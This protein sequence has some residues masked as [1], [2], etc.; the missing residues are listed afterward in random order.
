MPHLLLDHLALRLS[1]PAYARVFRR[2]ADAWTATGAPAVRLSALNERKH[3]FF[4]LVH[5]L[6]A[7]GSLAQAR[8]LASASYA[9]ARAALLL[10]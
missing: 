5:A 9:A 2:A 4:E 1:E 7:A 6:G 8:A 3:A 10:D